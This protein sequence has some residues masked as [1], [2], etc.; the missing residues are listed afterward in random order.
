MARMGNQRDNRENDRE[1]DEQNRSGDNEESG[2]AERLR[3]KSRCGGKREQDRQNRQRRQDRDGHH[4]LSESAG[5]QAGPKEAEVDHRRRQKGDEAAAMADAI[6]KQPDHGEAQDSNCEKRVHLGPVSRGSLRDR[7]E[8][9]I[10]RGQQHD[11]RENPCGL[12]S[13]ILLENNERQRHQ[14]PRDESLGMIQGTEMVRDRLAV[15]GTEFAEV[16]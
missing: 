3:R 2:L 10:A 4:I 15:G 5:E 13:S 8:C 12:Q 9:P 1:R 16:G 7:H 14:Q 6:G 11:R